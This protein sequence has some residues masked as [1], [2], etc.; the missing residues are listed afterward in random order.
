MINPRNEMATYEHLE[1]ELKDKEWLELK[2][3]EHEERIRL[4]EELVL[5][6]RNK[7]TKKIGVYGQELD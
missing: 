6:L 3:K 4:L 7:A 1:N 5:E 2:I